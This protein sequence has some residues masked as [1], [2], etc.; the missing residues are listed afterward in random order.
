MMRV[1]RITSATCPKCVIM[2]EVMRRIVPSFPDL[3]IVD[4]DE[5]LDAEECKKYNCNAVPYLWM[6]GRELVGTHTRDEVSA[7]LKGENI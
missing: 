4:L 7:F 5:E 1:I 3:E 6:D 2:K